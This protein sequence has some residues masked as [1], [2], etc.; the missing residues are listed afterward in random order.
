MSTIRRWFR[1][2][3]WVYDGRPDPSRGDPRGGT[4][5]AGMGFIRLPGEGARLLRARDHAERMLW[6]AEQADK[7]RT[8]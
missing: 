4:C 8:N 5:N 2:L 1:H 7:R 6:L 3:A